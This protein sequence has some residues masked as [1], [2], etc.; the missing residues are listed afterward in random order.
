MPLI[1]SENKVCNSIIQVGSYNFHN[2]DKDTGQ[3]PNELGN[4]PSLYLALKNELIYMNSD[5]MIDSPSPTLFR[6]QH[7][8]DSGSN[9]KLQ[10]KADLHPQPF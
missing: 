3:G 8:G 10:V 6:P 5:K 7:V 2:Y 1:V 9:P 4:D